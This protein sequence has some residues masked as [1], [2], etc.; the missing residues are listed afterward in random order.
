MRAGKTFQGT[1]LYTGGYGT[2][3]TSA[4]YSMYRMM[5]ALNISKTNVQ[6]DVDPK[7]LKIYV[8]GDDNP[9]CL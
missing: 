9:K 5:L 6:G 3:L 7:N 1:N 2:T 8:Q 4:H